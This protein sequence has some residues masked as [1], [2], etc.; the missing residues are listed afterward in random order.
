M[1]VNDVNEHLLR[2]WWSFSREINSIEVS[3]ART[4]WD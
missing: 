2:R 4:S 1:L 3:S